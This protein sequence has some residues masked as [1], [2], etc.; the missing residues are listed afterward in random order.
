MESNLGVS[1]L[2]F[3][4]I[5]AFTFLVVAIFAI[6]LL[7]VF[8][9]V[10]S[11]CI[12]FVFHLYSHSPSSFPALPPLSLFCFSPFSPAPPLTIYLHSS[13]AFSPFPLLFLFHCLSPLLFQMQKSIFAS[14]SIL[15]L[16]HFRSTL[17]LYS[18]FFPSL[19]SY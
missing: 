11:V 14:A 9:I 2:Q 4:T 3:C 12:F 19:Y 7:K 10:T 17:P 6:S 18:L 1:F 8:I 16:S 15:S 5:K 13:I